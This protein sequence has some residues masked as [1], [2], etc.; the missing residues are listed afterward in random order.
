MRIT[1]RF[2][3][4][5][6]ALTWAAAW[7]GA[8]WLMWRPALEAR[9]S[10][11]DFE[12]VADITTGGPA[13]VLV[14]LVALAAIALAVPPV[15]LALLPARLGARPNRAAQPAAVMS[16]DVTAVR[17]R[18]ERLEAEVRGL[19]ERAHDAADRPEHLAP[20]AQPVRPTDDHAHV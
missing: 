1:A 9:L 14:S 17:A 7:V 3:A 5:V 12:A 13:R 18:V 16:D 10:F 11:T 20:P 6:V 15:M 8:L 2:L 4:L 19:R